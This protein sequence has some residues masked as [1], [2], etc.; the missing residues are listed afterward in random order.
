MR[1]WFQWT[2]SPWGRR[3]L[4]VLSC[5]VVLTVATNPDLLPIL[6]LIDAVGLDVLLWLLG[7]QLVA[8]LAP[9]RAL[10]MPALRRV[11][12]AM[13][14]PAWSVFMAWGSWLQLRGAIGRR[15]PRPIRA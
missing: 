3:T 5:L 9:T 6:S 4:V 7:A 8:F 11:A 13:A 14:L 2:S 12:A 1:K 10:M 15:M